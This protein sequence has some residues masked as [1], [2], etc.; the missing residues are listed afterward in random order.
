MDMKRKYV[1]VKI[2]GRYSEWYSPFW[3]DPYFDDEGYRT[4][5]DENMQDE[6]IAGPSPD[7]DGLV[8][9][10][11]LDGVCERMAEGAAA[12]DKAARDIRATVMQALELGTTFKLVDPNFGK[13]AIT[14]YLR[15]EFEGPSEAALDRCGPFKGLVKARLAAL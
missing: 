6:P 2:E 8:I 4:Y 11:D 10:A 13:L 9:T 7:G 12:P 1:A 15:E 14:P 5:H 3:K